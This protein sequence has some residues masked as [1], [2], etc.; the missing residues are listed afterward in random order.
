MEIAKEANKTT[1]GR[2]QE[3]RLEE[4]PGQDEV[5]V[6][7]DE[8]QQPGEANNSGFDDVRKRIEFRSVV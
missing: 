3:S 7:A 4:S 8:G 6:G 1:M 5:A 2:G